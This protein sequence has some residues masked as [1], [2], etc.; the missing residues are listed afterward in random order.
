MLF[1]TRVA[2]FRTTT[3][4]WNASSGRVWVCVNRPL[5]G[6]PHRSGLVWL[7]SPLTTYIRKTGG[8]LGCLVALGGFRNPPSYLPPWA[9]I[10]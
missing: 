7:P 9:F 3:G 6:R 4:V 2:L 5:P 8:S 10:A 1:G